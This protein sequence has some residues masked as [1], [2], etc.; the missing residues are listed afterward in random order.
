MAYK[1]KC[2]NCGKH[3]LTYEIYEKKYKSPL[4]ICKKCGCEYIDPRCQ[5]LA[6]VGIPEQEFKISRTFIMLVIGILIVWRGKYLFGVRMLNTPDFI[7]WTLPMLILL[8]GLVFVVSSIV[9]FIRITSGSKRKKY[10]KLLEESQKRMLDENYVE[11][12]KKYGYLK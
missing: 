6:V 11:K 2:N 1:I 4:S 10:E 5:E 9:E 12:L 7:Q 8:L 3:L